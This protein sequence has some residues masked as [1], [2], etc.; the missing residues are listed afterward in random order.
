MP[1]HYN[2]RAITD[3]LILCLDA[4]NPKSYSGSG[5][6]WSDLSK[7]NNH[8][9][10]KNSVEFDDD[11]S[12]KFNRSLNSHV[13]FGNNSQ[14]DNKRLLIVDMVFKIT[15]FAGTWRPIFSKMNASGSSSTRTYAI[16][17]NN[18]GYIHFATHDG[19]SQQNSDT[20]NFVSLNQIYHYCAVMDK[21]VGYVKQYI[22][23]V[24]NVET[25]LRTT[26]TVTT[27]NP[28]ILAT[29][30]GYNGFGGN[31]YSFRIYGDVLNQAQITRNFNA[32]KGRYGISS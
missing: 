29:R 24:L 18:A 28:V 5:T 16:W 9:T 7:H 14:L 2:T 10:L 17:I 30:D 32:T 27:S 31:I 26:N 8:G 23:G 19:S 11:L 25:P 12:M 3:N 21:N 15:T 22:N 1:I 20:S 6:I 13:D 4:A